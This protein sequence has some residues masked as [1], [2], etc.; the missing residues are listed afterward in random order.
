MIDMNARSGYFKEMAAW[1]FWYYLIYMLEEYRN[2]F[3]IDSNSH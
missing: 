3:F 2:I 1:Y